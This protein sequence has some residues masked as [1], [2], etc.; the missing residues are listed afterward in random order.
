[1]ANAWHQEQ[2]VP[3]VA[4]EVFELDGGSGLSYGVHVF[5]KGEKS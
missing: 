2:S 4:I 1:V 3:L 5:N